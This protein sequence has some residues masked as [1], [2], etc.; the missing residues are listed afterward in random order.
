ML[1]ISP[2]PAT[3][4]HQRRDSAGVQVKCKGD[5]SIAQGIQYSAEVTAGGN[6][7]IKGGVMGTISSSSAGKTSRLFFLDNVG[8]VEVKGDLTVTESMVQVRAMV[9][10]ISRFLAAVVFWPVGITSLAG[11]FLSRNWV[12]RTRC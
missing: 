2:L 11:R 8:R 10:V 5:I 6:L 3:L 7:D 12:R 1:A 4:D 9:G